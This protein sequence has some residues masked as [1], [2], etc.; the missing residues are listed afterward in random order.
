MAYTFASRI[1]SPLWHAR[2]GLFVMLA[3]V[4]LWTSP[5]PA[6]SEE[7]VPAPSNQPA[8]KSDDCER[9]AFRVVVDVGH[10][11]EK[12][13]ADSSRGVTEYS[14]NLK[15][16]N[17]VMQALS[18]AGFEKAVRL[19]T[20]A[21]PVRGLLERAQRANNMRADLFLS[22]HHDSVPDNL[23]ET[24]NY[25]GQQRS[26][27]DRF[28]GYA[29]FIS[30]ENA[31]PK[32]SLEFGHFLGEELETRGLHYTPHYTLP[33]MGRRRHE[34]LDAEAGVYRYDQ[35]VVLRKT[36]MPAVLMEAGS[37]INRDEEL[38]LGNPER[39]ALT[40]AAVAAAVEDFCA[41][42]ARPSHNQQVK[43]PRMRMLPHRQAGTIAI[44]SRAD[45]QA[46]E[47]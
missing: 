34:L 41:T 20:T 38:E 6:H 30:K 46:G 9:S 4:L 22:I 14:F 12:P 44:R 23:L 24:W 28:K 26:F 47:K 8:S 39:R 36:L 2:A 40:S 13:G 25:E 17:E 33:L 1:R 3:T 32:G 10:T 43:Q 35:L 7:A 37:I 42:Q 27:S 21:A 5:Y 15:L 45:V 31:N 19:I 16:A 11:V 18:K 29:L